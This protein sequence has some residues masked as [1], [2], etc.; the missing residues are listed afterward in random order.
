MINSRANLMYENGMIFNDR[1][2]ALLLITVLAMN[3]NWP[4]ID[5]IV[6]RVSV[7]Q[8][9]SEFLARLASDRPK[10]ECEKSV[11]NEIELL[12]VLNCICRY[13]NGNTIFYRIILSTC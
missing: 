8:G 3:L 4:L 11:L 1:T 13:R 7:G 5:F 6:Y 2:E 12:F 9:L 10:L